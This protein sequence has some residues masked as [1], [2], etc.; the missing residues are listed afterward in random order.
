MDAAEISNRFWDLYWDNFT[1]L[2]R[3]HPIGAGHIPEGVDNDNGPLVL[4]E[5]IFELRQLGQPIIL[6]HSILLKS[7]IKR[8][9][10]IPGTLC[11]LNRHPLLRYR[12]EAHDNQVGV[13]YIC[14]AIDWLEPQRDLIKYWWQHLGFIDNRY[15]FQIRWRELAKDIFVRLWSKDGRQKLQVL[16]HWRQPGEVAR[17]YVVANLSPP[18]FMWL[19]FCVGLWLNAFTMKTR[20]GGQVKLA[21]LRI[22]VIDEK[23]GVK[24]L[25]KSWLWLRVKNYWW[26]KLNRLHNEGILWAY[27]HWYDDKQHPVILAE[28]FLYEQPM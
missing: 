20:S 27:K 14:A 17:A 13:D 2:A 18:L 16:P 22:A 28:E 25:L 5:S 15:P 7:T 24:G 21:R 23:K 12:S 26:Q 19:W 6:P 10:S 8:L 3:T 9:A 4:G 11:P 1:G